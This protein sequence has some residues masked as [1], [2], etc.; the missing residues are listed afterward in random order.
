MK[1]LRAFSLAVA[2][3]FFVAGLAWGVYTAARNEFQPEWVASFWTLA[4]MAYSYA[5]F[6]KWYERWVKE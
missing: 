1:L 4:G 3:V 6:A 2:V 5:Y